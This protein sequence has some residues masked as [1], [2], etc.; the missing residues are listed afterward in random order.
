MQWQQQARDCVPYPAAQPCFRIV[1]SERQIPLCCP[2]QG[3]DI[4]SSS[5]A[6]YQLD[7]WAPLFRWAMNIYRW[8]HGNTM[9]GQDRLININ[10]SQKSSSQFRGYLHRVFETNT[11]YLPE[12]A[13]P[14]CVG[15]RKDAQPMLP[16][17]R[18]RPWVQPGFVTPR[19]PSIWEILPL[20]LCF[21]EKQVKVLRLCLNR[22]VDD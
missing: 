14:L 11:S 3:G 6:L 19:P 10:Y 15:L 12:Q 5:E 20:L 8:K 13:L 9:P 16:P 22:H 2:R 17:S 1:S 4:S 7:Q 18:L 21:G